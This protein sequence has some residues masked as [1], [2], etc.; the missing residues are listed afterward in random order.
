MVVLISRYGVGK[1]ITVFEWRWW[2]NPF[3]I[4]VDRLLSW[5]QWCTFNFGRTSNGCKQKYNNGNC[6]VFYFARK[7][8][9]PC[10]TSHFCH[11]CCVLRL[12]VYSLSAALNTKLLALEMWGRVVTIVKYPCFYDL[13]RKFQTLE[14]PVQMFFEVFLRMWKNIIIITINIRM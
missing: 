7:W 6:D 8:Q 1:V 14:S 4:K 13:S 5:M 11:Y 9:T 12:I 3:F 10:R 2:E